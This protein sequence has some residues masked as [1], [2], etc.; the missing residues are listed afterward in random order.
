MVDGEP[1]KLTDL[2]WTFAS[3]GYGEIK[4]DLNVV[5]KPM[6]LAGEPVDFGIGTHAHSVIVY[7]LPSGTTRFRGRV[8][9]DLQAVDEGGAKGH[10]IEFL[11]S[12]EGDLK[13]D[14][15][16]A[17]AY[18]G[19]DVL[20]NADRVIIAVAAFLED[21]GDL[22]RDDHARDGR[23]E[24]AFLTDGTV[25]SMYLIDKPAD[26]LTLI[27]LLILEF[28]T[29][30]AELYSAALN[31]APLYTTRFPADVDPPGAVQGVTSLSHPIGQGGHERDDGAEE[32]IVGLD[33]KRRASR[34][35]FGLVAQ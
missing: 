20:D 29:Y 15:S 4:K 7:D 33:Q 19:A 13:F 35:Q 34:G 21:V 2:D 16:E 22:E 25:L 8:G 31:M 12:P 26:V 28:P 10:S 17:R 3:T 18:C 5:G 14:L 32:M 9:P 23:D 24:C 11:P 30:L 27:D 1:T 6:R